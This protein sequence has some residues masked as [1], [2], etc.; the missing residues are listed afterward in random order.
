MVGT[1]AAPSYRSAGRDANLSLASGAPDNQVC[2]TCE[3]LRK[4]VV[5]REE[6]VSVSEGRILIN[7]AVCREDSDFKKLYQIAEHFAANGSEVH[8]T[9]KMTRPSG[10]KYDCI[11]SQLKGTKYYGKCPD[12]LIDGQWYEHEGFTTK[13]SAKAFAN[14][15]KHGLTQSTRLILD[16]C[17]LP[18]SYMKKAIWIRINTAG[19]EIDEVWIRTST[20]IWLLYKK[21]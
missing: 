18:E 6:S 20:E 4:C 14:M 11:Y 19:K 1:A 13:D 10:F 2:A 8:L 12:L 3:M 21:G 7:D 17:G 15:L 16:D 5:K 9:P